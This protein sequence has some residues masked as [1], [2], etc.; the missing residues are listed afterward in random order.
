LSIPFRRPDAFPQNSL[1]AAR[2]AIAGEGQA[3]RDAFC[4]GVFRAQFGEGRRI[5]DP[6]VIAAV[7]EKAGASAVP[8]LIQAGSDPVKLKLRAETEQAAARGIFGAPSFVAPDG[9][10]FW[11]N[12][13]LGP[14]LAWAK[15][16]QNN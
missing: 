15:T 3:W 13:R 8:I 4:R 1:L 9:E 10:L 7:L 2:V 11:G 5:D 14:A 12:D 6:A 16:H